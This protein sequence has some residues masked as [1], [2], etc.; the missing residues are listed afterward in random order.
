MYQRDTSYTFI[1]GAT[2]YVANVIFIF[3]G[4]LHPQKNTNVKIKGQ[5]CSFSVHMSDGVMACFGDDVCNVF[6]RYFIILLF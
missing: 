6:T 5:L 2:N 1:L 3:L 4:S